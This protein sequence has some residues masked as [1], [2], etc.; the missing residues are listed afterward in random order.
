MVT[1]TPAEGEQPPGDP[2]PPHHAHTSTAQAS[3]LDHTHTSCLHQSVT[4][5]TIH[6]LVS[7]QQK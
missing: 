4:Q 1:A 5:T 3:Q 6:S 7:K 2:S